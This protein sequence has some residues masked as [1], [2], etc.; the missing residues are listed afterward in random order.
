MSNTN[1]FGNLERFDLEIE[2][3]TKI[4]L[5]TQP[6]TDDYDKIVKNLKVLVEA[7]KEFLAGEKSKIETEAAEA[8]KDAVKS[9]S[10][11]NEEMSNLKMQIAEQELKKLLIENREAEKEE[12]LWKKI[13]P[14]VVIKGG[15]ALAAVVLVLKHEKLEVIATKAFS[16]IPR[17]LC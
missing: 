5:R 1:D 3:L 8:K 17:L 2:N 14:N 12:P 4:L 10:T 13:D 7:R 6:D 15:I 11:S 16:F 9:E